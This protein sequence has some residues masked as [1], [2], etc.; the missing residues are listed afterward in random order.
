MQLPKNKKYSKY[1]VLQIDLKSGSL[2]IESN[3]LPLQDD[4]QKRGISMQ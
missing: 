4:H 3:V 2:N 1:N